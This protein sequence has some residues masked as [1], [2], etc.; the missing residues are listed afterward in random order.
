MYKET[1]IVIQVSEMQEILAKH[2]KTTPDKIK[3][4]RPGA[5]F[6]R[7]IILLTE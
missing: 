6:D 4:R 3:F 1:R 2:F 5:F 7:F